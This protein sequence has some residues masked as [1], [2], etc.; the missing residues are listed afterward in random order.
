MKPFGY[1][2]IFLLILGKIRFLLP[3][4]SDLTQ[5]AFPFYEANIT[6]VIA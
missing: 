4:R 5:A 2:S 1:A 6:M 3:V